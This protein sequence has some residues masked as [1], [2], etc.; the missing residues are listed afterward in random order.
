[1]TEKRTLGKISAKMMIEEGTLDGSVLQQ[2]IS[3]DKAS[4]MMVTDGCTLNDS[5]LQQQKVAVK[6]TINKASAGWVMIV[7]GG[8]LN[9]EN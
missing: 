9:N 3:L 6:R 1:M 8:L 4:R 5:V 7:D 2:V